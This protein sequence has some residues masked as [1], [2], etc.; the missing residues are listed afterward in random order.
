M[1]WEG[2]L[3]STQ[4]ILETSKEKRLLILLKSLIILHPRYTWN[5]YDDVGLAGCWLLQITLCNSRENTEF[6]KITSSSGSCSYLLLSTRLEI[7]FSLFVWSKPFIVHNLNFQ[8]L[9]KEDKQF[10][11]FHID[12]NH[13]TVA[14]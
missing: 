13:G 7:L 9:V 2:G 5:F 12:G 8:V 6:D 3:K 11:F 14:G 4:K 10:L 1:K